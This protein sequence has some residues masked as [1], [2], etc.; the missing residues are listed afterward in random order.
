MSTDQKVEGS[1]PSGR[2]KINRRN[3]RFFYYFRAAIRNRIIGFF[4]QKYAVFDAFLYKMCTKFTQKKTAILGG[5]GIYSKKVCTKWVK[6][7]NPLGS[8][9]C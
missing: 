2:A 7:I 8:P 5:L 1:N 3:L 4:C 9:H 6:P